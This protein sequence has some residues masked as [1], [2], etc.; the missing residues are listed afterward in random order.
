[1]TSSTEFDEIEFHDSV[2]DLD[3]FG[4]EDT[5][6]VC[7]RDQQRFEIQKDKAIH[8]LRV[9]YEQEQQFGKQMN[10]LL[11]R[12]GVWLESQGDEVNDAFLTLQDGSFAFVVIKSQA[13]FDPDLEDSLAELDV[14]I[15]ND[16]SLDLVG[17]HTLALPPASPKSLLSFLDTRFLVRYHGKRK[18]PHRSGKQES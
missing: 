1:M 8:A 17:V 11:N 10:L 7:P 15:A 18:R 16:A 14:A 5:V 12:L 6:S 2:V 3:W 4:P 9:A 13:R